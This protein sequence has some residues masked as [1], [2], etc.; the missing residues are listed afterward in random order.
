MTGDVSPM[1]TALTRAGR[2]IRPGP[3]APPIRQVLSERRDV[4][5]AT[6]ERAQSPLSTLRHYAVTSPGKL[7]LILIVLVVAFVATGLYASTILEKRTQTLQEMINRTEPLAEASQV[8]Y[9]SLSIADAA[10]NSAFISGGLESPALRVR[11]SDALA[12]AATAFITAAGSPEDSSAIPSPA[13]QREIDRDLQTLATSIPVYSGLIETARTNNRLGNP[14]G[15]AYL[16]EASA[17]MQDTILPAAENLYNRRSMAIADPQ[18]ALTVPPWGVYVSLFSVIVGLVMTSRYLSRRTRRRFNIG[19]LAAL[20]ATVGGTVWLLASGLMSVAA[21]SNARTEGADPLH[22]LTT[23]RILTQQARS[24]ETLSL[25]RREDQTA[26]DQSFMDTTA[27]IQATLDRVKATAS[28]SGSVTNAQL[29]NATYVLNHWKQRDAQVRDLMQSGN[30]TAARVLT[31]GDGK[32]S[33]AQAY[34]DLDR[35]FTDIITTTRNSFRDDIN[36]AQRVLGYTGTG[37]LILT[38]FGG[39]AVVLGLI[40][41]IREYR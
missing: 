35:A 25:A 28:D 32:E 16:G 38:L 1:R 8:L 15:S 5:T 11:Y 14:I 24:A 37:I 13:A 29:Y 36:T 19:V 12:T 2:T 31:V 40:P 10:A 34:E 22:E 9:S 4:I 20:V 30:F 6:R 18:S 26:L 3:S 41:R 27:Q 23:A 7:I 17:L 21:T 39:V 33:T